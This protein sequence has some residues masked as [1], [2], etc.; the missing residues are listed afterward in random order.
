MPKERKRK[1][2]DARAG[3]VPE[4]G[5]DCREGIREGTTPRRIADSGGSHTRAVE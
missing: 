4:Q 5:Q 2:R 1:K 3:G